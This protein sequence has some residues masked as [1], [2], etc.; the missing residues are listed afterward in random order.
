[1]WEQEVDIKS[2]DA[3]WLSMGGDSGSS[4]IWV[5]MRNVNFLNLCGSFLGTFLFPK[6]YIFIIF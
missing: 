6:F 4:K 1:M 3:E 5:R 2:C